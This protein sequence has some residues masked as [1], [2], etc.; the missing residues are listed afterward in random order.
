M[1]RGIGVLG[2]DRG[3][4]AGPTGA[5]T[6][7]GG[8]ISFRPV[9][10]GIIRHDEPV[11]DHG[12]CIGLLRSGDTV[13]CKKRKHI[14]APNSVSETEHDTDAPPSSRTGNLG[15]LLAPPDNAGAGQSHGV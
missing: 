2:V 11:T 5:R 1:L 4:A 12:K 10:A 13:G 14:A 8:L 9:G 3:A 7:R 6:P 15:R